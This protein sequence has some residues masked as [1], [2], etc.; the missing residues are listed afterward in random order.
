MEGTVFS[1]KRFAVHDGSGIRTT[2]FLKGC[3]LEC[4]WCHNPEG[5]SFSPEI[6]YTQSKCVGCGEC[7][8]I[9]K[10]RAHRFENG[11]HVF[12]RSRC[13]ACGE[14]EKACLG[15]AL[16]L[17]GRKMTVG[18]V[19]DA[20]AEDKCFYDVS[21][22]GV[23][24][25]GGEC[26]C[27][28]DFCAE[29]LRELKCRG[30]SCAVDTSGYA[31]RAAIAAVAPYTDCFLY[32]IKLID[33]EKHIRYTGRSNKRI[34]D[35]LAYI[36]TLGTDTEIRIPL[37]PTVND[38]AAEE[39]GEFLSGFKCICGVRVLPFNRLTESKYKSVGR[40]CGVLD[41]PELTNEKTENFVNALKRC[42]LNAFKG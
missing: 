7:V 20:V 30:I 41:L 19:A 11:I 34:L 42:G 36:D 14:C 32:D 22:G 8:G 6:I 29:L 15:N 18:E 35:N 27:S 4:R 33:D 21:G 39:F 13:I 40:V 28:A 10:N 12:E 38:D 2:V 1:I 26:L 3:P 37:I 5:I 23:T 16:E 25:S 31:D 24:L 9:C 17:C